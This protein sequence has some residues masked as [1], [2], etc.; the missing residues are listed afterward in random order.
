MMV[1]SEI[2]VINGLLAEGELE[3]LIKRWAKC[4][5]VLIGDDG[6]ICIG[7][8]LERQ[9]LSTEGLEVFVDWFKL[10]ELDESLVY[11][12]PVA[13]PAGRAAAMAA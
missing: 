5:D 3:K 4:S 12:E 10:Q 2:A 6:N 9:W 1:R 8:P 7:D 13:V 11:H